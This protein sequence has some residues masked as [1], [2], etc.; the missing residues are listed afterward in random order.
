MHLLK[1]I[2]TLPNI[3]GVYS[4]NYQDY[5]QAAKRWQDVYCKDAVLLSSSADQ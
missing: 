3:Q 4:D 2:N 5:F 1:L